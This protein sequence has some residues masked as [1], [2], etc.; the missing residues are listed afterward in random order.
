MFEYTKYVEHTVSTLKRPNLV[1]ER[2]VSRRIFE[3]EAT[4]KNYLDWIFKQE[5]IWL[6]LRGVGKIGSRQLRPL[7]TLR[8]L[9]ADEL[10]GQNLVGLAQNFPSL[11]FLAIERA[12]ALTSLLGAEHL[13]DLEFLFIPNSGIRDIEPIDELV[14]LEFLN[15]TGAPVERIDTLSNKS[16]LRILD[17]SST[18]VT[19]IEP[20]RACKGLELFIA[21]GMKLNSL[22]ALDKLEK[23]KELR[24][25]KDVHLTPALSAKQR[26]G[27]LTVHQ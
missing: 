8:F 3:H 10:D 13:V 26:A 12:A 23:L 22:A 25:D 7:D 15:I 21:T 16:N 17:I 19:S 5:P 6:D 27:T 9:F 18:K 1:G 24:L 20:I 11:R 2:V 4:A 14:K